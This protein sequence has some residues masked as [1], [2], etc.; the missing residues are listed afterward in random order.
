MKG[1]R[2]IGSFG[3][4]RVLGILGVF[5]LAGC[6]G[7]HVVEPAVDIKPEPE[8]EPVSQQVTPLY[9]RGYVSNYR[10]IDAALTRAFSFPDYVVPDEFMPIGAFFTQ[11]GEAP[12]ERNIVRN[13]ID[14]QW[15][16]TPPTPIATDDYQLY[17]YMPS[18]AASVTITPNSNYADGATMHFEGLDIVMSKDL[19]V[20]VGA[21]HATSYDENT[22]TYTFGDGNLNTGNFDCHMNNGA[23]LT[24]Y[25]FLLFDHIY[26]A[27]SFRFRVDADYAKMRTIHL[28]KLQLTAYAD[29]TYTVKRKKE[30]NA[31]ISL[32]KT[33]DGTSPIQSITLEDTP[34]SLEI[35]KETFFN[36][37]IEL[38]ADTY[39]DE[40]AYVPYTRSYYE[41]YSTYDVYDKKGNLIRQNCVAK[42]RINPFAI[43]N[44]S[45]LER[46]KKYVLRLTVAP[47]YL[48][49]LS[50]QDLDNPTVQ[51]SN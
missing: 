7:E 46:G 21:K 5:L 14:G 40:V 32:R 6:S 30:M 9:L 26:A 8:P 35:D 24:N 44:L 3:V 20:L 31:T 18:N 51:I 27:I 42:N 49:Q 11:S 19:C 13:P 4:L 1:R 36:D 45:D 12:E 48:Y 38:K 28:R 43:L 25:L 39:S 37:D 41:L 17:G 2:T 15:S 10:E 23:G 22:D 29:N 47:T 33:T 16:Y 50:D 34:G